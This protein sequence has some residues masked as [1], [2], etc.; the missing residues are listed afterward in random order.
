MVSAT[1]GHARSRN[2]LV[3]APLWQIKG[4]IQINDVYIDDRGIV[5]A[6]DRFSGAIYVLEMNV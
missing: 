3:Q 1:I 2:V 6:A 5:F 4:A